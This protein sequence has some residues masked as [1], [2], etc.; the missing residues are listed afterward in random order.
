MSAVVLTHNR[1]ELLAQCLEA[2]LRQTQAVSVVHVVDNASTDGTRD[3]LAQRGLLARP[4]V[5]YERLERNLG[6]AGGFAHGV[7]LAREDDCDWVWLMDD[8]AE[9]RAD[10]LERMLADPAAADER[11]VALCP[12]VAGADGRLQLLHRGELRGRPL[13]LPAAAYERGTTEVGFATFVGLLVRTAV[14]RALDPPIAEFFIWADDY[15]YCLRLG[16][17]GAIQ[18][19]PGAVIVHKDVAPAFQTRRSRFFNRLLGWEVQA[20]RY[21]Q[22]WRNLCGIRNWVWM[23]QR[24]EGLST[25]GF[26]LILGR[27]VA[28][29]LMYD[30][31]P[32]RRIPWLIRFAR[33]G[34]NG[35][36]ASFGP[37]EWAQLRGAAPR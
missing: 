4:Q 31:R 19:V 32:L 27:F 2:L 10:C 6:G 16:T 18:L 25:L 17:L 14:A 15:E 22:A 35:R 1:K 30:E 26:A 7:A 24:H 29:A 37:D 33:D 13:P 21:D 28:K 8:D 36:F 20:T 11:T 23:K 12:A 5:R 9:P 34:R 3:Y